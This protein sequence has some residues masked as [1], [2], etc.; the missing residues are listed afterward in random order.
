MLYYR[1]G[2]MRQFCGCD[3]EIAKQFQQPQ[4]CGGAKMHAFDRNRE[5]IAETLID[6]IREEEHVSSVGWE[7]L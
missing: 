5:E 6:K 1:S 2:C 7:I 4:N 3:K